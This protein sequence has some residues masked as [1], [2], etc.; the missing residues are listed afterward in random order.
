MSAKDQRAAQLRGLVLA[1][2]HFRQVVAEQFGI[3]M[4]EAAA[5]SHL[6]R[7]GP[8]SARELAELTGLTPSTV[9]ALL[10]R[11]EAADL[12]ERTPHPTD[13]RQIVV[14]LTAAGNAHLDRSDQWLA[15][16]LD[17]VDTADP[18]EADRVMA[19]LTAAFD[20]QSRSIREGRSEG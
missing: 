1:A 8:L 14:R 3:G 19:G 2:E 7:Q 13:R 5:L 6:R 11:L 16:V 4:T 17:R 18:A 9:T 12:A 15:E 20:A 10:G